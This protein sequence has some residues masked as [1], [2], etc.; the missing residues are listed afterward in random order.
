MLVVVPVAE[1]DGLRNVRNGWKL[2][3]CGTHKLLII[4]VGLVQS[5]DDYRRAQ[6]IDIVPLVKGVSEDF[7][8]GKEKPY[9]VMCMPPVS[10]HLP[11]RV[12]CD[13][14]REVA[15]RRNTADN[16]NQWLYAP[17]LRRV[18]RTTRTHRRRR[19]TKMSS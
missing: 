16:C 19:R 12:D 3:I 5:M 7:I 13:L 9:A 1:D 14:V 17:L 11:R 4:L 18:R 2:D 15:A 6:T 10:A 8:G